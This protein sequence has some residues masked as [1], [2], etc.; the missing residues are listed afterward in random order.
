[1]RGLLAAVIVMA[2]MIVVGTTTLIVMLAT[3]VGA[4]G[5]RTTQTQTMPIA[6]GTHVISAS[7]GGKYLVLL[8]APDVPQAG[9]SQ[10]IELHRLS[11]GQLV[12][13]YQIQPAR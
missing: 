6:A 1:M 12:A 11:D 13:R 8:L 3:R 7:T 4:A 2:V 9:A 5:G 10:E